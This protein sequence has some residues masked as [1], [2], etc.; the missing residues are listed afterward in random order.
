[1]FVFIVCFVAV[2]LFLKDSCY[3]NMNICY[4][5][6]LSFSFCNGCHL[7]KWT[8]EWKPCFGL[9]VHSFTLINL[10]SGKGQSPLEIVF[11]IHAATVPGGPF[12]DR[13]QAVAG[14]LHACKQD[15][16][17]CLALKRMVKF[18]RGTKD[19]VTP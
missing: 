15:I 9:T 2:C 11:I 16:D 18:S 6:K 1:M 17:L 12:T 10:C 14:K 19:G 8:V 5:V 7:L 4:H 3:S 13:A